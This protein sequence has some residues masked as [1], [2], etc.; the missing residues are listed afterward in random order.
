MLG[1]RLNKIAFTSFFARIYSKKT[2]IRLF[3][4]I[5]N[6]WIIAFIRTRRSLDAVV[7]GGSRQQLA[8]FTASRNNSANWRIRAD[9]SSPAHDST[10]QRFNIRIRHFR[11]NPKFKFSLWNDSMALH[12][13]TSGPG[14]FRRIVGPLQRSSSASGRCCILLGI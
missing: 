4:R 7:S 1:K 9:A 3:F 8:S 11:T 12:S 2:S 5:I 6:K 10:M 13:K 14:I